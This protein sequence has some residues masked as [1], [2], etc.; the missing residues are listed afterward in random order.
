MKRFNIN[1]YSTYSSKKASI[2]EILIRTLKGKLFKYFSFVGKYKWLGKPLCDVVDNYN[3]TVHRTTKYKPSDINKLNESIVASN[4]QKSRKSLAILKKKFEV[5]DIVRISKY[6]E[7][8]QKGYT[9]SWSTELFTIVKV[10]QSKPITYYL[11]DQHGLPIKGCFYEYELQKTSYPNIYL[12]EKVIKKSKNK[13]FV[14]WLGLSTKEN[15]WIDKDNVI[16]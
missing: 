6:K 13:V 3:H 9:P 14:K 5:G 10:L 1:H 7:E 15:S 4:I 16:N 11:Q 12:V 2:V 8:F